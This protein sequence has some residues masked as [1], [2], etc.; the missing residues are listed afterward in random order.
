MEDVIFDLI[1]K[2]N[3]AVNPEEA[4]VYE[5]RSE[6]MIFDAWVETWEEF[7]YAVGAS[8]DAG[9]IY[10]PRREGVY[11]ETSISFDSDGT[12]WASG[13]RGSVCLYRKC[14]PSLMF[15]M[16]KQRCIEVINK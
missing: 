7:V 6:G 10:A 5:V 3:K 14:P 9:C 4:I 8:K 12:V 11:G 15:K 2:R 16:Y 13:A 1:E